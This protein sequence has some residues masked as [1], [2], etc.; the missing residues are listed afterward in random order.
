MGPGQCFGEMALLHAE[1]RAANVM[2]LEDSQARGEGAGGRGGAAEGGG[3]RAWGRGEAA[4][5]TAL[6][7]SQARG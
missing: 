5:V 3:G 6:E 1:G 7:D 2:A 4:N